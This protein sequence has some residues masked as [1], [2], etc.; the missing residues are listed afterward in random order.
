[1]GIPSLSAK[2]RII[3]PL[4]GEALDHPI[5][6]VKTLKD[7]VGLFKVGLAL[8]VKEGPKVLNLI[9]EIAGKKVFL[10]LK[11]H[12][13]PETVRAASSALKPVLDSV[14][15]ITV[16]TMEGEAS[17]RAA[18]EA[19]ENRIQVLGITVLTSLSEAELK[20][21]GSTKT[22]LERVKDL[23]RIAKMSGC[24]GVVCS[25][26]EAKAVKQEFG[27]GFIAVTPGIRPQW[28]AVPGDDQQRVMTPGEAVRN[29]ADYVVVGRP[30]SKAPDPVE[31]ADKIAHEIEEALQSHSPK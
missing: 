12:D 16:H 18:V 8:F 30:I 6:W 2:D 24:A 4:D 10:D 28:A 17:V 22:V 23:A 11:F 14:Q 3:F 20:A 5:K 25:A 7:H 21:M 27:K 13:I 19:V 31:A 9:Q 1:V 15:F 26:Q 29:G